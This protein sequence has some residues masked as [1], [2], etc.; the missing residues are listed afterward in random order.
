MSHK[1]VKNTA[2]VVGGGPAGMQSALLLAGRGHKVVLV[3]RAPA[4]GG[5]FPL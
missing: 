2:I 3:E 1:D 5:L 4:L